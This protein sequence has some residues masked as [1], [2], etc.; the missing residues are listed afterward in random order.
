MFCINILQFF[1][2]GL[3]ALKTFPYYNISCPP[4]NPFSE[5]KYTTNTFSETKY[6]RLVVL[7]LNFP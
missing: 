4:T 1:E 2:Q 5:T 7:R 3:N 6:I